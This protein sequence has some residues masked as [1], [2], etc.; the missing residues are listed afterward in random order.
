MRGTLIITDKNIEATMHLNTERSVAYRRSK[1]KNMRTFYEIFF[2]QVYSAYSN[3]RLKR[4][5]QIECDKIYL[6]TS[7]A[8]NCSVENK[9]SRYFINKNRPHLEYKAIYKVQAFP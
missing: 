2:L 6:Y 1:L 4:E 5:L 9:F 8:T 3:N 7:D